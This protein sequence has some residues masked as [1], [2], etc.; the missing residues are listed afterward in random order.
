MYDRTTHGIANK[1]FSGLRSSVVRF[2]FCNGGMERSPQSLTSHTVN[3]CSPYVTRPEICIHLN[4]GICIK[5][6]IV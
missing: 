3:R 1:G 4:Q 6:T 2:K 5:M